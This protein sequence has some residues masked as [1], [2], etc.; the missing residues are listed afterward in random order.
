MQIILPLPLESQAAT[1]SGL[2]CHNLKIWTEALG[3][4]FR[5]RRD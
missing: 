2:I 3:I 1:M 5:R 4:D